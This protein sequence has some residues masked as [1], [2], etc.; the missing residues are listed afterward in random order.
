MA[1][2]RREDLGEEEFGEPQ[3]RHG[4]RQLQLLSFF[5]PGAGDGVQ[6]HDAIG[7]QNPV[8]HSEEV[9]VAVMAEVLASGDRDD[10]VD[11]LVEL[12]PA[13]E[14]DAGAARV[15][16]A[17]EQLLDVCGLIAAQRQ[18]DDVDIVSLDRPLHCRAPTA[19]DIKH[20]HAGIEAEFVQH[21]VDLG[22]LGLFQRHVVALKVCTAAGRVPSRN[23]R[24]KSSE[25]S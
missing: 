18:A 13:P 5:G 2:C 12:L 21:K 14:F 20:F 11:G 1:A 15:A 10:A 19:A 24:K 7:R 23:S 8:R 6:Q 9:V 25:R 16:S 22:D 4:D 3:Q 17:G